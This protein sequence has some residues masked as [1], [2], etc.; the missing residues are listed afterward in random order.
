MIAQD[1]EIQEKV[2]QLVMAEVRWLWE[3]LMGA[4][5]GDAAEA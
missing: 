1:T 2:E 5:S 4:Q 3:V